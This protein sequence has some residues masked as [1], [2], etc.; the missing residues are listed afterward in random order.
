[1]LVLRIYFIFNLISFRYHCDYPKTT[2]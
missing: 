2:Y 1:L